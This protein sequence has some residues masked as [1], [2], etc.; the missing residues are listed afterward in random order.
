MSRPEYREEAPVKELCT[1]NEP[2][3]L[4]EYPRCRRAE[5]TIARRGIRGSKQIAPPTIHRR[6]TIE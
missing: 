1:E 2:V 3:A 5:S 6:F 4:P